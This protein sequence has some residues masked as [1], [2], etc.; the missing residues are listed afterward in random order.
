MRN[1]LL[2]AAVALVLPMS[3]LAQHSPVPDVEIMPLPDGVTSVTPG[4]GYVDLA[5]NMNPLGVQEIT[6][7]FRVAPALNPDCKE[8]AVCYYNG[9]EAASVT[10]ASSYIDSMGAPT[11]G[12]NFG[13]NLTAPGTY[14]VVIPEGFWLY[15]GIDSP[16]IELNYE[17]FDLYRLSPVAGLHDSLTEIVMDFPLADEVVVKNRSSIEFF[18]SLP[19]EL[20]YGL[21]IDVRANDTDGRRNKVVMSFMD[22]STASLFSNLS[23]A[24]TY[25]FHCV[26]GAFAA[27][28]YGPNHDSDPTDYT[29][30]TTP[31]ILRIYEITDCPAPVI[32]PAE[33]TVER[34][35]KFTLDVPAPFQLFMVDDRNNKSAIYPV[36]P[37]G[38]LA[39]DPVC[40]LKAERN[41]DVENQFF[42]YVADSRGVVIEEGVQ[43]ENGDY[44]LVLASSLY[45]GMFN[46]QF[47]NSAPYQYAYTVYN[48]SVK[49]EGLGADD[50]KV[51]VYNLAGVRVLNEADPAAVR[52]LPAGLYIVNGR[53]V[54]VR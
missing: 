33:G 44:M 6:V 9:T 53:K 7:A 21:K 1:H 17:I 32:D 16:R 34:F 27:Y 14:N 49:V 54:A 37:D 25:T 12:I 4:Q 15:N 11:A 47:V 26:T 51:T 39:A 8:M 41:W 31:E 50:D 20:V 22:S 40:R 52:A 24:G 3:A 36:N 43:P 46:G 10:N 19:T 5:A 48:E 29:E 13:K 45:S 28:I 18:R 35:T 42:L 30:W 2:T 23:Q 38:S